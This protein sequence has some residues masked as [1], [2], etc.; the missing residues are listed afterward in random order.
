MALPAVRVIGPGRAGQS[1]AD[2]LAAVGWR[3]HPMLGRGDDVAAAA[4]DV[5][6]LVIATPDAAVAA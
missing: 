4:A 1:L 2:A 6:L 5:D 3:V